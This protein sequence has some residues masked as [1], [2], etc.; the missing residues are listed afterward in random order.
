MANKLSKKF[1]LPIIALGMGVKVFEKHFTLS[2]KLKGID[3]KA[4]LD[5]RDFKNYIE[6]ILVSSKKMVTWLFK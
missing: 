4:S 1:K 5:V 2:N 6:I 3:Q